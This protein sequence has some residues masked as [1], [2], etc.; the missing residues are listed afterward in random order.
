MDPALEK[1]R[2]ETYWVFN[3]IASKHPIPEIAIV[4]FQMVPLNKGSDW[5]EFSIELQAQGFTIER[6]QHGPDKT[7]EIRTR[8]LS[9]SAEVIWQYEERLTKLAKKYGFTLDGWGF[10]GV[11]NPST[12]L[13]G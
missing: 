10:E 11:Q 12:Y 3:D 2:D 5:D 13:G 4:E 6:H 9:L 8:P 1:Q 7:L